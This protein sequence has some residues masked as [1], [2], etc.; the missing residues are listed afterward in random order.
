MAVTGV[1]N[2]HNKILAIKALNIPYLRLCLA[3]IIVI[4]KVQNKIIKVYKFLP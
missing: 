2:T 4:G 1:K 3:V